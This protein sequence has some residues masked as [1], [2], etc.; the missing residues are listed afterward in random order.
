VLLEQG[1]VVD[2]DNAVEVNVAGLG[3]RLFG[4]RFNRKSSAHIVVAN[5]GV[6]VLGIVD[7]AVVHNVA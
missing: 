2:I 1:C 4:N 5:L 7:F 3:S 6:P